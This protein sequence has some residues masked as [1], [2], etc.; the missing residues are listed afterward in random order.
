V[1]TARRLAAIKALSA[2]ARAGD[3]AGLTVDAV[4]TVVLH[5][6]HRR[7]Y[8]DAHGIGIFWPK[9]PEDLDEPSSP[10]W[11]DFEYYRNYLAFA[12]LTHWDEFLD[13]YVNQ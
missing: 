4:D 5:E 12:P 9:V 8:P 3:Q 11:N 2:C 6:W 7:S 13:A 10:Q 1:G